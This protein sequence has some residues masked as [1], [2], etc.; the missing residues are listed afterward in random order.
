MSFPAAAPLP[1]SLPTLFSSTP[2]SR[3]GRDWEPKRRRQIRELLEVKG[4]GA[5]NAN[6][7][8][9]RP[10]HIACQTGNSHLVQRL[11]EL[12]ENDTKV[13]TAA[14]A[15]AAVARLRYAFYPALCMLQMLGLSGRRACLRHGFG[16][17]PLSGRRLSVVEEAAQVIGTTLCC[18]W[19]S[20]SLR[21]T[22]ISCRAPV[23]HLYEYGVNFQCLR[24]TL[25]HSRTVR[26][27][28]QE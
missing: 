24:L 28:N 27:S 16:S 11:L 14:A 12:G 22:Y 25:R 17:Y 20:R 10:M 18:F 7:R 8:G 23:F 15:A 9:V 13:S 2:A 19:Y 4:V 26:I 21:R 5:N 6:D 3:D 1:R